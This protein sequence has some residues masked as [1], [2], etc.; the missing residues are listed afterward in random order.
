MTEAEQYKPRV[1]DVVVLGHEDDCIVPEGTYT[2]TAVNEN[3]SF[4]VGG[5]IG[6]WPR[7]VVA[8]KG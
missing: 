7:R 1:G 6:V 3:G 2:V 4:H 5:N 8:I